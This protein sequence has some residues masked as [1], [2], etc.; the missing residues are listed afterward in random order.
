MDKILDVICIGHLAKDRI[1]VGDKAYPATGGAVYYGGMVLLAL[2]LKVAIATRLAQSDLHLLD[3]LRAAGA[4]LFPIEAEET[5][6][7]ENIYP[8]AG[9]DRRICHPLGFAGPFRAEDIPDLKARLFYVGPIMPGEVDLSFLQALAS[10]GPLALDVQGILRKHLGSELVIGGWPGVEQGLVLVRYLKA[11][12]REAE[13]LTGERDPRRAAEALA[14]YGPREIVLTRKE[15]VV[16]LADG[17]FYEAPFRP[18]SLAGRTGRGD[19]CFAAYLGRRLMG[20][21]PGEATK[22]AAALTT[23]K[24]EQPGP[25][26]GPMDDVQLLL[27]F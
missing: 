24:L 5:S 13:A 15:G 25:F 16:V 11:D 6:G 27:P 14:E 26:R 7:I 9:S 12:D 21:A 2:G 17:R 20:D 23:L 8:N 4:E 10:R 22:F 19:T 18:R 3:E 1:V